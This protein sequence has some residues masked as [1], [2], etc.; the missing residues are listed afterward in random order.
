MCNRTIKTSSVVFGLNLGV[1]DRRDVSLLLG[2]VGPGPFGLWPGIRRI[3][4][5]PP[6]GNT[7]FG[8]IVTL[9]GYNRSF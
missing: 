8:L 5:H 2:I 6:N 1:G 3:A 4:R 7:E 9:N